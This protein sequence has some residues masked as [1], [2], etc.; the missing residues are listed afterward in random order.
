MPVGMKKCA[1]LSIYKLEIIWC[2]TFTKESPLVRLWQFCSKS[3]VVECVLH[4]GV[5]RH[6]DLHMSQACQVHSVMERLIIAVWV[7]SWAP[8]HSHRE[9]RGGVCRNVFRTEGLF[10]VRCM[11]D[12]WVREPCVSPVR[13]CGAPRLSPARGP[14]RCSLSAEISGGTKLGFFGFVGGFLYLIDAC[15]WFWRCSLLKFW[16]S[17]VSVFPH[18]MWQFI[19]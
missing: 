7:C 5:L 14:S 15:Y 9:G 8:R 11:V 12:P 6:T 13:P 16:G 4:T 1:E 10:V 18:R 3:M 19:R 2:L 17:Q